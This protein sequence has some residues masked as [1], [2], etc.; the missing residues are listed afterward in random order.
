MSLRI[1]FDLDGVLADMSG[2][3][4]REARRLGI[5]SEEVP[6]QDHTVSSDYTATSITKMSDRNQ[7][8]LWVEVTKI[9][10]FWGDA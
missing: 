2:A 10:N 3:L 5:G 1:A 4:G 8:R 9:E 7:R 6:V